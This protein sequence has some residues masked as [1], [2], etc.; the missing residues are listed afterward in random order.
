[1]GFN[2]NQI[3]NSI[4]TILQPFLSEL[5]SNKL[6]LNYFKYFYTYLIINGLT[7]N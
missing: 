1:M 5:I 6:H 7:N 2:F 4:Q 3:L